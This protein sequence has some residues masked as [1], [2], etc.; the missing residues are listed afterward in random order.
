MPEHGSGDTL[1]I[2]IPELFAA[3]QKFYETGWEM[4]LKAGG[5]MYHKAQV[6]VDL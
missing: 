6:V 3:P 1:Y 4:D 2:D 5:L